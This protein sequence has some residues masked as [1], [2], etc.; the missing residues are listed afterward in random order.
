MHRLGTIYNV[1]FILC[2]FVGRVYSEQS[3][4]GSS[5][6]KQTFIP[7]ICNL[8][9]HLMVHNGFIMSALHL[10]LVCLIIGSN[11]VPMWSTDKQTFNKLMGTLHSS[12]D[13]E[14]VGASLR[15]LS[16]CLLSAVQAHPG[17]HRLREGDRG[18][19]KGKEWEE[20]GVRSGHCRRQ[21]AVV[22][23]KTQGPLQ[24]IISVPS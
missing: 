18:G 14:R 12:Q 22:G 11:P 13:N 19:R 16:G 17:N 21:E 20:R 3:C 5:I 4:Q 9:K 7:H 2:D 8:V 15:Y 6:I 23:G 10:Y 24:R 1:S